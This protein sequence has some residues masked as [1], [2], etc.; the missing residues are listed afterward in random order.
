MHN[1]P[2]KYYLI[3]AN[4]V[5]FVAQSS[6]FIRLAKAAEQFQKEHRWQDDIKER[7]VLYFDAKAGTSDVSP[8]VEYSLHV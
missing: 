6:V 7:D 1:P 5:Y 2:W 8:E 4:M 3:L